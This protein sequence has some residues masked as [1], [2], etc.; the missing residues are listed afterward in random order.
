M[1]CHRG[2]PLDVYSVLMGWY[3]GKAEQGQ[4]T[5]AILMVSRMHQGRRSYDR[6]SKRQGKLIILRAAGLQMEH[7]HL[8]SNIYIPHTTYSLYACFYATKTKTPLR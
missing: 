1:T 5:I 2:L 8:S 4:D 7:S 6:R 3:G